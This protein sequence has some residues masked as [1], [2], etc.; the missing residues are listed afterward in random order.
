MPQSAITSEAQEWHKKLAMQCN[1]RAWALSV[2]PRSEAEDREMLTAAHTSAYHW[3]LIGTELHRMRATMLL[4]E[5]H[6][7]LGHGAT[8]LALA[9]DMRDYFLARGDT[10][11]WEVAFTHAIF[12]HCAHAAGDFPAHRA[13]YQEAVA[14]IAAIAEQE[15]RDIVAQTFDHVPAP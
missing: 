14:A 15:D 1:N 2:Q 6:A 13:A 5:V 4:A 3:A 10:P 7:L 8:A 9:A 11:D 12:A